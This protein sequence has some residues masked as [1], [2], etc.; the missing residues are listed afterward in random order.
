MRKVNFQT[1]ECY[2]IFNRGVDQRD[3]FSDQ[4]DFIRF[5]VSIREFNSVN[6][7]GS[8]YEKDYQNKKKLSFLTKD[9]QKVQNQAFSMIPN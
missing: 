8:I 5:I 2:H 4:K 7:I 9:F 6:P 1:E 3:I